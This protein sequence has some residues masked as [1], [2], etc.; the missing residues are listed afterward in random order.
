MDVVTVSE[1]EHRLTLDVTVAAVNSLDDEDFDLRRLLQEAG[2]SRAAH[3]SQASVTRLARRLQ[4][5]TPLLRSLPDHSAATAS[6]LVNEELTELDLTPA[7]V[8]HDDVGP[9]LHWTPPTAPFDDQVVTDVLL[10]VARE[11]CDHG[12]TRFGRCAAEGCDHLFYDATRNRSR[13]F[14]ADPRCASRTHT[15]D[16]RARQRAG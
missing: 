4:A 9:H 5:L 15:A 1:S 6:P 2:F 7:I 10:T 16:H 13:R 3:A 14:C 11:V 12:T 8:D